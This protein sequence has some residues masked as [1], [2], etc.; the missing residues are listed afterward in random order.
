[1]RLVLWTNTIDVQMW[2]TE[3]VQG[4]FEADFTQ[5][6]QFTIPRMR[7]KRLCA[8]RTSPAQLQIEHFAEFLAAPLGIYTLPN[9]LTVRK[10]WVMFLFV[11]VENRGVHCS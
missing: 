1:M 9:N 2:I 6:K 10:Y 4:S 11:I 8:M 5:A 3:L 7:Y